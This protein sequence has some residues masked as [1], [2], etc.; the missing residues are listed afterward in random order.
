MLISQIFLWTTLLSQTSPATHSTPENPPPDFSSFQDEIL[1]SGMEIRLPEFPTAVGQMTARID[2]ELART[3]TH[4]A[5][6]VRQKPQSLTFDSAIRALD[7][8]TYDLNSLVNEVYLMK[9]TH[10]DAAIRDEADLLIERVEKWM[11]DYQ[12]REDVF[13]VVKAFHDQNPDLKAAGSNLTAEDIKFFSDK[14][15][16][17]RKAGFLLPP[18]IRQQVAALFKT[19]ASKNLEF[20]KNIKNAS[21]VLEFTR[22]ELLGVP[23]DFLKSIELPNGNYGVAINKTY[24]NITVMDNCRVEATRKK[25]IE[26]YNSIAQKENEPILDEMLRLRATIATKL[27]YQSWAD[28][29]IDGMMAENAKTAT[30]FLTDL[31]DRLEP[32]FLSELSELRALKVAETG[33]SGSKINIW[34]V[35]YYQEQL[36]QK[37]YDVNK[38]ALR[39]FFSAEDVLKGVFEIYEELFAIQIREFTPPQKYVGDLRSYIVFDSSTREPMG[40]FY[41]DLFPR[42]GKYNHFAHF[43]IAEA[44]RYS[45]DRFRRPIS[46]LI[47]NFPPATADRPS[48]FSHDDVETMFHEFGH[49][50]HS[51]LTNANYSALA[52]TSV[53]RDFVEAPSQALEAWAWDVAVLNKFAKHYQDPS[54]TIPELVIK[55]MK[56]AKLATI[57]MHYRRQMGYALTDQAF[58]GP[59]EIKSSRAIANREMAR[60]Y[61]PT[62]EGSNFAAFWGHMANYDGT[63][64]GYAWADAIAQDLLTPFGSDLMNKKAGASLRSEIYS[65]GG[66][67]PATESVRG[68]IGRDWNCKAFLESL[69]LK[70][71]K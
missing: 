34:D 29:K 2:A 17:Y 24:Q 6:Y 61:F 21:V 31:R 69:G 9:E 52:G 51:M 35:R 19:L 27:G 50:L 64:Y 7:D 53:E 30:D 4:I 60:S 12:Y 42:E 23:E 18:D 20:Q 67:R 38:E 13:A 63:Y 15:R 44:K 26:N 14:W 55:K 48:L 70:S 59:G 37:K 33:D 1:K 39:E 54:K 43:G 62:P 5:A 36:K 68:F 46:A 49:L 32:K 45:P 41:L 22:S 40:V 71:G 8:L 56:E 47:C 65:R 57:G 11:I 58:H 10:P 3:E 25:I 16:E 28:Y 66:S